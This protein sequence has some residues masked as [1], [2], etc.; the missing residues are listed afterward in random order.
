MNT[1]IQKLYLYFYQ[2]LQR[3]STGFEKKTFRLCLDDV[4]LLLKLV[5]AFR[6]LCCTFF[7]LIW[8]IIINF[9]LWKGQ[10]LRI[11]FFFWNMLQ[12]I[13]LHLHCSSAWLTWI[14]VPF[15]RLTLFQCEVVILTKCVMYLSTN[16]TGGFESTTSWSLSTESHCWAKPT[17]TPWRRYESPCQRRGTNAGWSSWLWPDGCPNET[18]WGTAIEADVYTSIAELNL[19]I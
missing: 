15:W 18:R 17:R 8:Q 16:R 14:R 10:R 11:V 4:F 19:N 6:I 1:T 2:I 9:S 12:G 13:E 3:N 7:D 5:W